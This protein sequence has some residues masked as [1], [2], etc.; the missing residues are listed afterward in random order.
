MAIL[1]TIQGVEFIQAYCRKA[2]IDQWGIYCDDPFQRASD[3]TLTRSW[4]EPMRKGLLYF[5][6]T[7]LEIMPE[8]EWMRLP[9]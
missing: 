7:R 1:H 4:A 3:S 9:K 6:P 2:L 8:Q 5:R